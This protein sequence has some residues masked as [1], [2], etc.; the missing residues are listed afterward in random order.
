MMAAQPNVAEIAAS[1]KLPAG[2]IVRAWEDADFP[3]VQRLSAAEGWPTPIEKPDEMLRAWQLS[4]PALVAVAEDR[5]IGFLR[6]LSDGSVTTY[7]AEVLIAP[8]WRR[9]GVA[10]TLLEAC[11]RLYP[12]SRLDLLASDASSAFYSQN[13]F[14]SFPGFR[15]SWYEREG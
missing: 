13:G 15:L 11:H 12:G 8:E 4:R 3:A 6:A 2:V 9:Q 7:V 14:R 1:L 10:S 5:V